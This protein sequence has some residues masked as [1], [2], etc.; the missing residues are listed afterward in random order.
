MSQNGGNGK[1]RRFK[2]SAVTLCFRGIVLM[3]NSRQ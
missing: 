3:K 1:T 2:A